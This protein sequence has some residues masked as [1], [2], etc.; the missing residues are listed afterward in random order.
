MEILEEDCRGVV[1]EVDDWC[2]CDCAIE[3]EA[4]EPRQDYHQLIIFK[5]SDAIS[6]K[7]SIGKSKYTIT[8]ILDNWDWFLRKSC[9]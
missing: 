8:S 1:V 2:E 3:T 5:E 7:E 6:T 9:A 4:D